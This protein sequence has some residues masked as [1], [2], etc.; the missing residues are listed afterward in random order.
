MRE[1]IAKRYELHFEREPIGVA[2][3]WIAE[4]WGAKDSE[5]LVQLLLLKQGQADSLTDA[6]V[7][8]RV[9]DLC[10][11]RYPGLVPLVDY[12]FDGSK[13]SYYFVY[14]LAAVPR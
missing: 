4:D 1:L 5:S 9:D 11:V 14:D 13:G 8:R 7:R 3:Y 12:G 6:V 10:H 2:Q